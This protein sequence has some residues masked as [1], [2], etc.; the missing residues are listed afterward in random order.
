VVKML[1][2]LL[3]N[4]VI[5]IRVR[6]NEKSIY[7][8]SID[9]PWCSHEV[10]EKCLRNLPRTR[11]N[12]HQTL[13]RNPRSHSNSLLRIRSLE[14]RQDEI[15]TDLL[16]DS[17]DAVWYALAGASCSRSCPSRRI[18]RLC[19]RKPVPPLL[20]N[21]VGLSF[22]FWREIFVLSAFVIPY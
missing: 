17:D 10:G 19:T 5:K 22:F 4:P 1:T 7:V 13:S 2:Y 12:H 11:L 18:S 16:E 20:W 9:S 6:A 15:S 14:T 21:F 8:G 3:V